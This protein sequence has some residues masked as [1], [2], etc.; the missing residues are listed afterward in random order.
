MKINKTV[1]NI[2]L[3]IAILA[4]F[5]MTISTWA[6]EKP[7]DAQNNETRQIEYPPYPD[8]WGMELPVTESVN[9]AGLADDV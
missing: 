4:M 8:V 5:L 6:A 9:Y 1:T 3:A 2:S 7:V